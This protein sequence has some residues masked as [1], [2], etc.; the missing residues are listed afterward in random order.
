M[1]TSKGI[2]RYLLCREDG[3]FHFIEFFAKPATRLKVNH[4]VILRCMISYFNLTILEEN[5]NA[6]LKIAEIKGS[7]QTEYSENPLM[8]S[9]TGHENLAE[10]TG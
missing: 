9:P 8:R 5:R 6:M 4:T 10:L 7:S 3:A 1:A 2:L